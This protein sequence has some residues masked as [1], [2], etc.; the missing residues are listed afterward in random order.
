M[1]AL[2]RKFSAARITCSRI[3]RMQ[4]T[5]CVDFVFIFVVAKAKF[6]CCGSEILGAT[7]P[8]G[9]ERGLT[10]EPSCI[11]ISPRGSNPFTL[12][13]SREWSIISPEEKE[14][15]QL[16][17]DA[18]GEFWMSYKGSRCVRLL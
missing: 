6:R 8:N 10:S 1:R 9:L 5:V 12:I 7:K 15:L 3:S 17:F 18:D 13:R 14:E 4:Q 16:T 2:S 11:C